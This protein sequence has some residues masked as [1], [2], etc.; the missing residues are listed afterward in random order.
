MMQNLTNIRIY[1]RVLAP[2]IGRSH[3]AGVNSKVDWRDDSN[4][5][6]D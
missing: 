3:D 5:G 1:D 2:P 4:A 6:T